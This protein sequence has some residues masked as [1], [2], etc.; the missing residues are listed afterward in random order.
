M[1]VAYFT[2]FI[3]FTLLLARS[4]GRVFS[5]IDTFNDF[6]P[7][8][9]LVVSAGDN[10]VPP[11]DWWSPYYNDPDF[12]GDPEFLFFDTPNAL[13]G[14]RDSI[15]GFE[16]VT[17]TGSVALIA[18]VGDS[19]SVAFPLSYVGG[20]YFQWDGDDAAG[21]ATAFPGATL[22][23]SPGIGNGETISF[24]DRAIDFTF[25]GSAAG[26]F[27]EISADHE[28]FYFLDVKDMAGVQHTLAFSVDPVGEEEDIQ[29]F[30]R[31]DDARWDPLYT[32]TDVT[33]F[34]VR[35]FTFSDGQAQ[36]NSENAIDTEFRFL[37]IFGYE[38]SGT[39]VQDC[40]CDGVSDITP[41]LNERVNLFNFGNPTVI[42][43]VL[44]DAS[45]FY[46]FNDQSLLNDG[47]Y[48]VCLDDQIQDICP[49][50]LSCIDVV[51]ANFADSIEN[52]FFVTAVSSMI[53]PNDVTIDCSD[54]TTG[55]CLGFAS[56]SGCG[57]GNTQITDFTDSPTFDGC[58]TVIRRTWTNPEDLTTQIQTITLLD[59]TA[60]IFTTPPADSLNN[61]CA[62]PA[63]TLSAWLLRDAGAV[64]FDDCNI[65]A[66]TN[67][68]ASVGDCG[69]V[70][71]T[72]TV[73]D[74]CGLFNT[75]IATYSTVDSTIPSY[76]VF[77]TDSS[78]ECNL[79]TGSSDLAL[80]TWHAARG[81]STVT[82]DCTSN[83]QIVFGD[84][85]VGFP[86]SCNDS[87][88]VVYTATDLCGNVASASATFTIADTTAPTLS[89]LAANSSSECSSV[90][91]VN[92]NAYRS[93][94]SIQG[95]AVA[96]D[97]C[98]T[99]DANLVWSDTSNATPFGGANTCN[100]ANTIVFTVTDNCGFTSTT[101]A[102]FTVADTQSP[103]ITSPAVAEIVQCDGAG[104]VSDFNAFVSRNAD[105]TVS[106]ACDSTIAF[107][108]DAGAPPA[109]CG[110]S[111]VVTFTA[112]DFC[113]VNTVSTSAS[114]TVVDSVVPFFTSSPVDTTS[115]CTATTQ[116]DFDQW[117][118]SNAF[119]VADDACSSAGLTITNNFNGA[120]I[121]VVCNTA[122]TVLFV[123]N[124]SCGNS[125]PAEAG[126]FS[127]VDTQNPIFSQQAS[128]LTVDCDLSTNQSDY[129]AWLSTNGGAVASDSCGNVFFTNDAGPISSDC[130]NANTV[131][132]AANDGCGNSALSTA[133]FTIVDND[134][135]TVVSNAADLSVECNGS[136]N[137]N[138]L[139][140]W[141]NSRGGF[142]A[143]DTCS[144][145][146]YTDNFVALSGGCVSSSFVTFTACDGCANCITD[147]ATFTVSDT[148]GPNISPPATSQNVECDP[149]SNSN[150]FQD[151][152]TNRGG[153]DATD[154][155]DSS[156][157]VW[158]NTFT[159]SP[160]GCNS[161]D[162]VF[163]VTDAC[164]QSASTT[165]TFTI[166][167]SIAPVFDP[168]PQDL[169]VECDGSGNLSDYAAW[170]S[171]NAGASATDACAIVLTFSSTTAI[172]GPVGCGIE[173]GA[174]TVEDECG[175]AATATAVFRVEDT[176][177]PTI[178]PPAQDL[179]VECDIT[180]NTQDLTNWLDSNA[181]A[182]AFDSC[183]GSNISFS[184]DFIALVPDL[185]VS[186]ATV[187]FTAFDPC[188]QFS[189]TTAVFTID[190][191][192]PP[193]IDVPAENAFFEC[194]GTET[195]DIA[196]YIANNG[197][198]QASDSCSVAIF[199]NDFV[200]QP[201][202]CAG[203]IPVTF[204]AT[205]LCGNS[206]I[207]IGSVEIDD[208]IAPTFS[209]FPSDRTIL[210][211]Q[212]SDVSQTGSPL[213]NDSCAASV[214]PTFVDFTIQEPDERLCPGDTI[215]TRTWTVVDDC[216]NA[217]V[218]DQ[219]ITIT[220]PIGD[221][222]PTDCPPCGDAQVC[223]ESSVE[224]VPCNPVSCNPVPC[225]ST[226]CISVP[227]LPVV[228]GGS[229]V[230]I[231]DDDDDS[232]PVPTATRA[233]SAQNCDPVYIYIFDD[234]DT[235][236]QVIV[237]VPGDSSSASSLLV[238]FFA[239]IAALVILM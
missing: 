119:A 214:D 220:I 170:V 113:N 217:A 77:P 54:C 173:V 128:P 28:V 132:F 225:T 112:T 161:E 189:I 29:F 57:G 116:D 158:T 68:P 159:S 130:L 187:Q 10:T 122:I 39:V 7:P 199:T 153:A 166:L 169:T 239:L 46:V 90:A 1:K 58:N 17:P 207:T 204:T 209:N 126:V 216:G 182:A 219:V 111:V 3:I 18:I 82:D 236:D 99:N 11:Y 211:D 140:N 223:C 181:G 117:I 41:V 80:S 108:N 235:D 4:E 234:D 198:A 20:A 188:G 229:A 21:G 200:S 102:T 61:D 81:F 115:E 176:I 52:N 63:E 104:N 14:Q 144:A 50:T 38:I 96:T 40:L 31:F 106:D 127:I 179:T 95:G 19:A 192:Q 215:I 93:W 222:I 202:E 221:C 134:L 42:D 228:C 226:D 48:T 37:Q 110:E 237:N 162:V 138:D 213:A 233:P 186:S 66:I 114:F 79:K 172:D 86:S 74:S 156:A 83:G 224:P 62:V 201:D 231:F 9:V 8:V 84:N 101:S 185:C 142:T 184:N 85:F 227:C 238:S 120:P 32:F 232:V 148:L 139:N 171:S 197:N 71:V 55:A 72:F 25:G 98:I 103:F 150:Q 135:P 51:L 208:T 12:G 92:D 118:G 123:A 125:S 230:P 70:D 107:V 22:N 5:F 141:L 157:L 165:A 100:D 44:T 137:T 183:Y 43:F 124:D 143:T 178:S 131:T 2:A 206:V 180:T 35:I 205:D 109:L 129:N 146:T 23:D 60:P 91:N 69:S 210:C 136:G 160:V 15:L 212:S 145:V 24:N 177:S 105:A 33:A 64:G 168:T 65:F 89:S 45:G 174:F 78:A 36:G 175:N 6:P 151:F 154:L 49:L 87:E 75:A 190:D 194:D 53:I 67:S 16:N 193:V 203:P 133:T 147:S 56:L 164:L 155:C 121:S 94:L 26:L 59:T 13:G 97:D 76:D 195:N 27:I 149:S 47:S 163:T 73:T 88:T 218:R 34:Q 167:D 30:F 191:T 196:N 152:L